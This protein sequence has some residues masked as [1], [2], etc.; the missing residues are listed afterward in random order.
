MISELIIL[1]NNAASP[2]GERH[3][4]AQVLSMCGHLILIDCGEGTQ[5]Q[6]RNYGVRFQRIDHVFIS[7]LHG[8]HYLGLAGLIFTWHLLARS[9]ALHI[10]GH[11]MLREILELQLD[12]SETRLVYPLEFHELPEGRI[13]TFDSIQGVGVRCFPLLHRVPTHGFVFSELPVSN[14]LPKADPRLAKL[15]YDKIRRLKN[16]E[17]VQ[18]EQ[19]EL[20]RSTD[21]CLPASKGKSYAYCSDTGFSPEIIPHISGVDLLYHEATFMNEKVRNANEK[22]HSTTLQ[23]AEIAKRAGVK[24][25]IIGHFSSRYDD[26][27]LPEQE[28]RT[29]FPCTDAARE[30]AHYLID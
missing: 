16:G 14:R 3:P 30:G 10:Y 17:D 8:D 27:S 1:G 2:A 12:A 21:V 19:G 25:L 28:A 20:I 9:R 13:A 26:I 11:P 24:K 15:H 23:A 6:L 7:H 18:T 4:S 29:V 5:M 22:Q